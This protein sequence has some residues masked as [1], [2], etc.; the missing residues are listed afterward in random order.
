MRLNA[1]SHLFI[2]SDRWQRFNHLFF[3]VVGSEGLI[4]SEECTSDGCWGPGPEQCLECKHFKFNGTCLNSCSSSPNVYQVDSKNCAVCHAECKYS[5]SGP[6]ADNCT[7]CLNV[8]DGKYCVPVCPESKYDQNGI[9]VFCHETCV[10]CTGPRNTIGPNG[11]TSCEK[12]IIG[13]GMIERCLKKS[14]PCPGK[15]KYICAL[16]QCL[17]ST[18]LPYRWLL[19]RM[20]YSAGTGHIETTGWQSNLSKVSPAVQTMYR[21]RIP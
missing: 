21:L 18:T 14:E 6:G 11:C 7:E 8:R 2:P 3:L 12:A 20:G 9:C 4:C 13:E 5:C 15:S 10:G 17:I 16:R 19:L 1:V